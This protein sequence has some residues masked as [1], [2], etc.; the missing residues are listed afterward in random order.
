MTKNIENQKFQK[1]SGPFFS[2]FYDFSIP[3]PP[4]ILKIPNCSIFKK[5]WK[6]IIFE[7]FLARRRRRRR[8]SGPCSLTS[9]SSREMWIPINQPSF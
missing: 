6:I 9:L 3:K 5:K 7:N 1:L 4:Q 2:H 8:R